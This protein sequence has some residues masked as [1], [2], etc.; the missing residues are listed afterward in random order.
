MKIW[1]AF[2]KKSIMRTHHINH[3]CHF[4]PAL[5]L[6]CESLYIENTKKITHQWKKYPVI[7]M[8]DF[9]NRNLIDEKIDGYIS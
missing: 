2:N 3:V 8:V 1:K 5:Y 4:V 9:L 6:V 7:V